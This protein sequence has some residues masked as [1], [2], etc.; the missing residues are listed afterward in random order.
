MADVPTEFGRL[1]GAGIKRQLPRL[2]RANRIAAYLR[3]GNVCV[4]ATCLNDQPRAT[5]IEYY[6]DGLTIYIAA[7]RGTKVPNL[8][9]NPRVSVAIY[10]TPYTDWTDWYQVRGLQITATPELLRFNER[11]EAYVAALQIY[12]WRKYRRALGKADEEPRKT[13][14]VKLTPTRIEFRDLGL[15]REGYAVLQTWTDDEAND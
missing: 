11:P 6:S 1:R 12:D 2:E 10:S 7:S 14:V 13:T 15:L 9:A 3:E 4:L 8:E 5:P